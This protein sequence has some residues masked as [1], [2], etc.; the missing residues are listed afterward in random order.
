MFKEKITAPVRTARSVVIRQTLSEQFVLAFEAQV[1]RNPRY[2]LPP[3][4]PVSDSLQW[5]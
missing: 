3:G 1:D 4:A 5:W 2:A